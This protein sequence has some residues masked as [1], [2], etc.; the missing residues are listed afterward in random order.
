VS[1]DAR[2]CSQSNLTEDNYWRLHR[3]TFES[4]S[5]GRS[6]G[7]FNYSIRSKQFVSIRVVTHARGNGTILTGVRLNKSATDIRAGI[8][9]DQLIANQ[10]GHLTRFSSLELASDPQRQ[11]SNCDSGYSCAYQCNISWRSETN[12]MATETNP[13]LVFERMFGS[14]SPGQRSASDISAI[15]GSS[16]PASPSRWGKLAKGWDAARFDAAPEAAPAS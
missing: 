11:S 10:V 4:Y 15:R 1:P 9:I 13:R 6:A 3:S 16:S 12:P 7:L 8:S 5:V 2:T 14:G